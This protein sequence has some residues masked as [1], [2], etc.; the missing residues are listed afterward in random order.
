[1]RFSHIYI[2]K[3][4]LTHPRTVKLLKEFPNSIV[5]EIDTYKEVFNRSNLH[6]QAQKNNPK[7]ILASKKDNFIYSGS[8]L[9]DTFH[10]G[11]FY[12]NTSILNCVYN[13]DYCFLQ[14]MYKSSH[15]VVFI[16]LENFYENI[17]NI[18]NSEG[19]CILSISYE[20]DL[21]AIERKFGYCRE[22]IEF[23]RDNKELE[24]EIR[25]K[26]SS[27][28][29]IEHIEPIPNV[30]LAWTL[31]P[32]FVVKNYE[33]KTPTLNKRL[34]NVQDAVSKGWKVRLSF[35]PLL[36][37]ENWRDHYKAFTEIV[38]SNPIIKNIHDISLGVFR[39]S[40]DYLKKMKKLRSDSDILYYPYKKR[41]DSMTYPDEIESKMKAF[42][43]NEISN[44]IPQEK[45]FH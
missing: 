37:I 31:S 1:M 21:L 10:R 11:K 44:Y 45:I 26:S 24:L 25:T 7:L 19:K 38:F 2:E 14:G 39:I 8:P 17:K 34:E 4:I 43:I 35:D 36:H 12:Y 27:F 9:T 15:I 32:E 5:I 29:E 18:I 22:W 13:C 16:N 23:A 33:K 20:T 3:E 40:P 42:M 28:K 30:I 41:N 6:F